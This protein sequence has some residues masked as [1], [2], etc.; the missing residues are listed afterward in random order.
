M[1]SLC[2]GGRIFE[3]LSVPPCPSIQHSLDAKRC[4]VASTVERLVDRSAP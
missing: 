4:N 3:Q 2:I 1:R